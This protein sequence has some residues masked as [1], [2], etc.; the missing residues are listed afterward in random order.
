M[1]DTIKQ[2]VGADNAFEN[3]EQ[4]FRFGHAAR[5]NFAPNY[6]TWN[7]D[8]ENRL[9]PDYTGNFERDREYIRRAY[10]YRI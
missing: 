8:L 2:A 3:Y 10:E 5:R 7:N 4:A 6:P 9:R 1:D